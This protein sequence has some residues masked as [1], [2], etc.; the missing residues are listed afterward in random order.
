MLPVTALAQAT[1]TFVIN[2][3]IGNVSAPAKVYLSYQLGAN[4][5]TDSANV[6]NG[7]FSFTGTYYQPGQCYNSS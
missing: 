2:G 5:I 1:D 4:N 7:A 6:V 3:K